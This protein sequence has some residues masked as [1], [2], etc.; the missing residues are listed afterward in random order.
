MFLGT[1][2]SS[3][4][5]IKAPY[6][7]DW[8]QSIALHTMQVNAPNLTVRGKS[9]GFYRVLAGTGGI[10]SSNSGDDPSKLLFLQRQQDSC[11]VTRDTSGISSRLGRPV[12]TLLDVRWE[13]QGPFQVATVTLEFISIFNNSQASSPF[14]ALNS[15]CL[16]RCQSDVRLPVQMRRGPRAFSRVSTGDPDIPSSCEMKDKP[17]FK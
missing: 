6:L 7:F 5:H 11:L 15:S 17:A 8:E 13:T 1:L 3:M 16:S 10:F 14:E 9:H 2:W 4:K 12:R